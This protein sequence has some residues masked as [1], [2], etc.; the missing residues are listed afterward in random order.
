MFAPAH[1]CG[2]QHVPYKP[3]HTLACAILTNKETMWGAHGAVLQTSAFNRGQWQK[4][5]QKETI[6]LELQVGITAIEQLSL[7]SALQARLPKKHLQEGTSGQQR[8]W[9]VSAV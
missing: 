2:A 6:V 1:G 7:P 8:G 4:A 5:Q 9:A 3:P